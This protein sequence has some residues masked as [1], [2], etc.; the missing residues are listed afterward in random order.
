MTI[1]KAIQTRGTLTTFIGPLAVSD[2]L[3]EKLAVAETEIKRLTE[4]LARLKDQLIPVFKIV[5]EYQ[6]LPTPDLVTPTSS[7]SQPSLSRKFSTKKLFLSSTPRQASPVSTPTGNMNDYPASPLS[8]SKYIDITPATSSSRQNTPVH[9]HA[10][11]PVQESHAYN[12][13]SSLPTR[14][15]PPPRPPPP[16]VTPLQV[17][18]DLRNHDREGLPSAHSIISTAHTANHNHNGGSGSGNS[19]NNTSMSSST[20]VNDQFKSFRVNL[21]DPC[22][23]VLPAALKRYKIQSDWRDYSL[24]ICYADQERCL[25]LEEKPLLVFQELQKANKSPVFMLRKH[26]TGTTSVMPVV[27]GTTSSG[28]V[29]NGLATGLN[30]K[31]GTGMKL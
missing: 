25:G 11:P 17:K 14:L 22:S 15:P 1:T 7:S 27:R 30:G 2:C 20:S 21:D 9:T 4:N 13:S 29:T 31:M 6:P 16:G 5:K 28:S 12:S 10:L 3:D 24:F 19:S 26:D 18:R 23:K 8:P